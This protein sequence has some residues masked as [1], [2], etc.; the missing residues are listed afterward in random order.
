MRPIEVEICLGTTC[1][2]MG[3]SALQNLQLPESLRAKVKI[4]YVRCLHLCKNMDKFRK[5]PYARIDG[6]VID[7]AA[8]EKIIQ[9]ITQKIKDIAHATN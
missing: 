1:F 9:N 8:P 3:A 6:E 7:E 4:S 2:V 5:A